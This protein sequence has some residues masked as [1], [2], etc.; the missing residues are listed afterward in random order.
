MYTDLPGSPFPNALG[1]SLQLHG[2][3]KDGGTNLLC[4]LAIDRERTH[5]AQQP[6]A[7]YSFRILGKVGGETM[8][9]KR[10]RRKRL[11][12]ELSDVLACTRIGPQGG[13]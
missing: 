2:R 8:F 5:A 10:K 9:E 12:V 4:P 3:G 1:P 6:N 7:S 13:K 11:C